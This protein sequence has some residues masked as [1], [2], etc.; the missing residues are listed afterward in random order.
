ML[1]RFLA[2][3]FALGA[4]LLISTA[5]LAGGVAIANLDSTPQPRAGEATTLGFTLLQH[6]VTPVTSGDV[7][8]V[9]RND[10][11]GES[12]TTKG[13]AE[14][15]PGHYLA[16]MTFPSAGSWTWEITL[17]NLLMQSKFPPLT[18]LPAVGAPAPAAPAAT[19]PAPASTGAPQ[20]IAALA[21]LGALIAG[22]GYLFLRR[23]PGIVRG[24]AVNVS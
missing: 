11:T 7:S 10:A 13:H 12:V 14:G 9:A 17:E 21:L 3:P 20:A 22:A 5:A 1:R 16:T 24:D 6:G 19:E 4:T 8:V 2:L 18:V 23:R 15:K